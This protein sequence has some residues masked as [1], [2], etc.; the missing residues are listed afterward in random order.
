M[1]DDI[2]NLYRLQCACMYSHKRLVTNA[3]FFIVYTLLVIHIKIGEGFD[4]V[5]FVFKI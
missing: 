3:Y 2:K 4:Y 1:I 5:K